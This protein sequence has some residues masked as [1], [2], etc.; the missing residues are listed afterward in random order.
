MARLTSIPP[1]TGTRGPVTIYYMFG[2]P[3]MRSRSSLT[4]ERVKKDPVFRNTMK[5]ADLMATGSPI[6]SK[7]YAFVLVQH[8][9]RKL[10]NKINGEVRVWLKYGWNKEDIIEYLTPKYTGVQLPVEA[11]VT[12]LRPSYRRSKPGVS[13]T[14]KRL[15]KNIPVEESSFSLLAWR[16]R[17]KQFRRTG[18]LPA[19]SG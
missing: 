8:K 5:N 15:F 17:D 11:P 7:V 9:S 12:V 19:T 6:A 1:F 2:K 16:R 14:A 3:F 13:R 4:G 18:D 10:F